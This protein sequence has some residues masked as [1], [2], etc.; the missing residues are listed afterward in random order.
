[1]TVSVLLLAITMSA[2]G[3]T[4]PTQSDLDQIQRDKAE[5]ASQLEGATDR[6]QEA[7][8]QLAEAEA[9]L[10]DAEHA[11]DAARGHVAAAEAS[12]EAAQREAERA[13][14]ELSAAEEELDD[15][16]DA[17]D[18]VRDER[19]KLLASTYRGMELIN[20]DAILSSQKPD[21]AL[22]RMSYMELLI[23]RKNEALDDVTMARRHAT[24]TER[25][26]A[27]ARTEAN[28][29][30]EEA[31]SALAY[32]EE[33]QAVAE[34]ARAEV[35][36]LAADRNDA[37]ETAEEERNATEQQWQELDAE[38]DRVA[39]ELRAQA[40]RSSDNSGSSGSGSSG[41]SSGSGSDSGGSAALAQ[42]VD[43]WKSSDF[44]NRTHP[45][46]GTVR[47]HGGTDFAAAGG[48]PIYASESGQVVTAGWSGGY[49]MFTC[50]YH[51]NGLSTCYAHQSSID[52]SNGQQV[53]R[54][55]QIGAVGTTGSS[56]GDHL[57]FE[58]RENGNQVEPLN[59]LPSCLCR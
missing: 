56:T 47:F 40:A 59:Y 45:I 34:A 30:R 46:Y 53:S 25:S 21:V 4:E 18:E 42:P 9:R 54:G 16:S 31:E 29:A 51:G 55:Q 13:E 36:A 38:S 26:A 44:G 32:A 15:A 39:E 11:V 7:G 12:A 28:D 41:G 14:E 33:Q 27:A 57:H 2:P 48:T 5:M 52:V 17:V 19:A 6:A 58:V 49:G 35:V 43:G 8:Q 50:I 23:D 10:P 22:E 3:Q 24:N 1:M 37:L 20:L